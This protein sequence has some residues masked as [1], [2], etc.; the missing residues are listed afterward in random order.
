MEG[1]L[2]YDERGQLAPGVAQRWQLREHGATFW[3]RRDARWSDGRPVTARDF[4]FE[5]R[6]LRLAAVKLGLILRGIAS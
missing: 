3:L 4:V 1:L 5:E 2:T 6:S